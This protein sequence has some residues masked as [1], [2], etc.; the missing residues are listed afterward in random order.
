M[1]EKTKV[2]FVCTANQQRSPTAERIYCD[3]PRFEVRSA[4]TDALF[5]R[6]LSAE[7]LDWADMVVVMESSHAQTIRRR[8]TQESEEVELLVLGIPDVYQFMEHALQREIRSRFEPL[9]RA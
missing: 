4:G 1:S 9:I 3:D 5:G 6:E 2:L 8:F 7:D